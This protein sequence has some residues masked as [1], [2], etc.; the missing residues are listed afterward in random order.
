[1]NK[2][3]N[4]N[5]P[6]RIP[7]A[8]IISISCVIISVNGKLCYEMHRIVNWTIHPRMDTRSSLPTRATSK[9]PSFQFEH[10]MPQSHANG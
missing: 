4:Q 2:L 10:T 8:G 6:R 5:S 7:T 3:T 1:M 9:Q